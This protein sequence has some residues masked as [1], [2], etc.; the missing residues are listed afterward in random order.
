M[1]QASGKAMG[2]ARTLCFITLYH[3]LM[4]LIGPVSLFLAFLPARSGITAV[5]HVWIL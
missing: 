4:I 3:T 2:C 1:T 5:E